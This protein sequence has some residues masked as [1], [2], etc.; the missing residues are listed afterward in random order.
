MAFKIDLTGKGDDDEFAFQDELDKLKGGFYKKL[1]KTPKKI[2]IR[3]LMPFGLGVFN[4]GGIVA[5][6]KSKFKGHF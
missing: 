3:D 6:T 4:K 5:K 1:L 2:R